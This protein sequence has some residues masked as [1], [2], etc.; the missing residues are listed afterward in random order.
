MRG[1]KNIYGWIV[2][3]CLSLGAQTAMAIEEPKFTLVSKSQDYEIRQYGDRLAIEAVQ[4]DTENAAFRKLFRYIS[5]ANQA[6]GKIAMTAPVTQSQKVDM[7][8]PVT[9]SRADGK[10]VMRFFLPQEFDRTTAPLPTDPSLRLV[11]VAG[12]Y[13][14]VRV[15][16]GRSTDANFVKNAKQLMDRLAA[17]GIKTISD[18]IKATYNGPFTPF[19]LRRNEVMVEI[20]P[21][22]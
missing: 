1:F 19:F 13:Y 20:K 17:D 9:Q 22:K 6:Q 18:P 11:T 14:A 7:T 2:A 10:Q 16:A 21:T 8:A 4:G 3:L 5:G 15:Y 12:G